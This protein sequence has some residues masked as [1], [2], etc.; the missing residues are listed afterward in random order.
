MNLTSM[1]KVLFIL[2]TFIVVLNASV[3]RKGTITSGN[4]I[5]GQYANGVIV[6]NNN[7]RQEILW[8]ERQDNWKVYFSK[9]YEESGLV[10]N[11]IFDNICDKQSRGSIKES[12]KRF[13][14]NKLG[15][16]NRCPIRKGTV[17][18]TYPMIFTFETTKGDRCGPFITMIHIVENNQNYSNKT[19]LLLTCIF[20]GFTIGDDC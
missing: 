13:V 20:R 12:I 1:L 17:K 14:L 3:F 11:Y 2:F 18:I 6:K 10:E 4:I 15:K 7:D 9:I 19:P 8:Q 16:A 5:Q